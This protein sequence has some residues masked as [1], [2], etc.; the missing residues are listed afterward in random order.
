MQNEHVETDVITINNIIASDYSRDYYPF[1]E[2]IQGL[3]EWDGKTDYIRRFFSLVHYTG[4]SDD[5][6]HFST[7][8]WFLAMV[9]SVLDDDVVNHAILTFI[10]KQGTYKSSFMLHILPPHL[11]QF[12][13]TKNNFSQV[14]KD[15]KLML[16]SNIVIGL[17]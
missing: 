10:G 5:L 13:S 11:R 3:P 12:Y 6:F 4:T 8:C 15:D 9:A 1:H 17:E 14:T 16:A 7:R 2:W